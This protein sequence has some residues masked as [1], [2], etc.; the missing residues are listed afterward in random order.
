MWQ[1]YVIGL[2]LSCRPKSLISSTQP[3]PS[4]ESLNKTRT[5]PLGDQIAETVNHL[6]GRIYSEV[7]CEPEEME[8]WYKGENELS[9]YV[10]ETGVVLAIVPAALVLKQSRHRPNRS[11]LAPAKK[12]AEQMKR[13]S[14]SPSPSPSLSLSGSL[15]IG[16]SPMKVTD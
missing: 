7:A 5:R 4:V 13:I 10:G 9:M 16:R 6:K 11:L 14:I 2:L 12:I 15:S 8:F 3:Q 1:I